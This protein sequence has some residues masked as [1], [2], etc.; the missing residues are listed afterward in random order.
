[1]RTFSTNPDDGTVLLNG[2]AYYMR[3]TNVCIGRFFE[4][5]V[6]NVSEEELIEF[7]KAFSYKN[8]LARNFEEN[9]G[10]LQESR[11]F[12]PRLSCKIQ[13]S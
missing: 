7:E 6:Y 3:G 5:E 13:S 4:D 10:N 2:K 12:E 11:G 8:S 9:G 1:M